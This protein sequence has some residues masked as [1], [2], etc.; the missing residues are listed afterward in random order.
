MQL[1]LTQKQDKELSELADQL[2]DIQV[3]L[4]K[5]ELQIAEELASMYGIE[6]GSVVSVMI[7]FD[8]IKSGGVDKIRVMSKSYPSGNNIAVVDFFKVT[9]KGEISKHRLYNVVSILIP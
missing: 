6:N 7:E 4:R 5:K 9:I 1:K 3:R 8:E 2:Y